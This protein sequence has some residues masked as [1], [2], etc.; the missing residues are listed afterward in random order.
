MT[1]VVIPV[2]LYRAHLG[3]VLGERTLLLTHRG[4]GSG[5]RYETPIVVVTHDTE[6][7]EYIVWSEGGT[8]ADWYRNILSL[9][10][11][12][13]QV[14]NRRWR[15]T[16]RT[17]THHEAAQRFERY[18][19][20]HPKTARRL[21]QSTGTSYDGTDEGR[22]AMVARMPMVAFSDA[23]AEEASDANG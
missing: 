7:H 6:T 14:R 22:L 11:E 21:L 2:Y 1:G 5:R 3:F 20:Q 8:H 23:E 10:A 19:Q 18:E 15:P 12:Q 16:Q 13:V 4:R 9:P 17:L